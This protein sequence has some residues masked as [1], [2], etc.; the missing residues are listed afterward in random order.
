MAQNEMF[1]N[2]LAGGSAGM[3]G[4]LMQNGFQQGL[5]QQLFGQA[6][7]MAG[8]TDFSALRDQTLDTLR[9]QAQP[10]EERAF[11]SLQD[12]LFS[13]GRLGSSGG[14][15]QTEAFARGLGQADLQRQLSATGVAQQQQA[16]NANIANMFGGLGSNLAGLE[17]DLL[18]QA[19]Q[20]FGATSGLAN[21]LN[22]ARF[23]RGQAMFGQGLAGL[24]GQ[25]SI[26]DTLMGLGTFGAN[27]GAQQANTNLGAAGGAANVG[28]NM[29]PSGTDMQAAFFSSL[30]SNLLQGSGGLNSLFSGLGGLFQGNQANTLENFTP[31][32][33]E[34]KT[35]WG[36]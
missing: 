17:S 25:Q 32:Q 23:G 16:Q 21:D 8:Q 7:Q 5:Q 2:L 30:G 14:A 24:Q 15:L 1:A 9:Q 36:G 34:L 31:K 22:Q 11:S 28:L 19:F 3:A 29:G 35:P 13:T 10:F 6:G 4:S 18:G 20:R 26:M 12:N 27:L 33:F